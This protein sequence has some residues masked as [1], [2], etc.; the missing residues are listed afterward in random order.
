MFDELEK[1]ESAAPFERL[2]RKA[3][4]AY[5]MEE[6]KLDLLA[7][8]EHAIFRVSDPVGGQRT[9]SY[10]LRVYPRGWDGSQILRALLWQT[11]LQREAHVGCP[12]PILT[13]SGNLVQ[14][15]ST[16]GV[17]GFRQVVVLSWVVGQ[18]LVVTKWTADHACAAGRLIATLHDHAET[19]TLPDALSPIR[20]T[21]DTLEAS[22]N[23][24]RLARAHAPE[25]EALFEDALNRVRQ[26]MRFL[27]T[28]R[29]VAGLVHANLKPEHVL[30]SDDGACP[31]G[32]AHTR[33]SHYIY[34]LATIDLQLRASE[35]AARLRHG[36]LEGYR[37]TRST[38]DD[39]TEHLDAFVL[40][41][42][43]DEL[44][45]VPPP[46]SGAVARVRDH[47]RRTVETIRQTLHAQ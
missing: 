37:S 17:S 34:D 36:L 11:A 13:R 44:A 27:G 46:E 40:L 23:P 7:H 14:S 19:F 6:A 22:L 12:E 18:S 1:R 10:A 38:E 16:P 28:A 31:L 30:F 41:R 15:L 29:D 45:A 25:E 32:F 42:L 8:Q 4:A 43:L 21:A 3:L 2:A 35:D 24:A 26:A 47:A 33:W 9:S 39:A 5:G 20:R